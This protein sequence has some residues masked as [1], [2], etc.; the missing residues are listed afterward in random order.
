MQELGNPQVAVRLR[1]LRLL[2]D[3]AYPEAAVRIAVLLADADD[4]VQLEAVAAELNIFL[5]EQV[6][7]RKHVAL[8][9]EHNLDVIKTADSIIDL[10]PEGGEAGG[11]VVGTGTPEVLASIEGSYTAQYL[12]PVLAEGRSHAY[13]AGR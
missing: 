11:I 5:A 12:R 9:I 4:Q 10:G 8:V 1:A 7:T 13:A 6:V 2:K 3:A